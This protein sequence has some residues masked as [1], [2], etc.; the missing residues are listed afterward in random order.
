MVILILYTVQDSETTEVH[1]T[2]TPASQVS[3]LY[4][5]YHPYIQYRYLLKVIN[6]NSELYVEDAGK[7]SLHLHLVHE[8]P[9][10]GRQGC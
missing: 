2:S 10:E 3:R 6:T 4:H 1:N 7:Y 9:E 8:H 5:L